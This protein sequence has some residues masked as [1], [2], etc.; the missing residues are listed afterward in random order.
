MVKQDVGS[1]FEVEQD[2]KNQVTLWSTRKEAVW[3][4]RCLRERGTEV[5]SN[6]VP[7]PLSTVPYLVGT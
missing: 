3:S 6:D 2:P 1:D 7:V 4:M 5:W